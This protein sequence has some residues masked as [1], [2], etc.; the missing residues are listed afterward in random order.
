MTDSTPTIK[1]IFVK[2]HVTAMKEEKGEE[3][4]RLLE[5]KYGGPLTFQN[6]DNIPLRDE[7][8]LLECSVELLQPDIPK[9][10]ISYEAGRLHFKNFLKT[11]FA[12]VL[13]PFF[14]NQFKLMMLQAHNIAGHV[15][16][17]VTFT[18][19]DIGEHEVKVMTTHNDYPIEHFQGFLKEW[20]EYAGLNGIV[21]ATKRDDTYE[22][23]M[24]W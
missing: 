2:A 4:L 12:R 16:Q 10:K 13:F 19:E 1:G 21:T 22:Y 18:T 20:M 17:G 15:F 5:E 23:R 3:G 11:P 14:K 9:D 24:K 6:T 7:V 8:K